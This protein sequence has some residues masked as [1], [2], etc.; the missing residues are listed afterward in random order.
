MKYLETNELIIRL[1]QIL[2]RG[3]RH[4]DYAR[5]VQHADL[6][7]KIMTGENM[8]SLMRR[9][10]RREDE[11]LFNQRVRITQ[12]IT[13][14]VAQNVETVFHKIPR[15][16]SIQKMIAYSN[17][18]AD[19]LRRLNDILSK[20]WGKRS[21]DDY[22]STRW[23][24]LN[25]IDPNSFIVLE[26]KGFDNATEL[27]QPYPYEVYAANAIMF[28]Y[29][30]N[31][32]QY[33][34]EQSTKQVW[35]DDTYGSKQVS[36]QVY[37]IYGANQTVQFEEVIDPKE[38][39]NI[40]RMFA[41]SK[42]YFTDDY[43]YF[44]P[45]IDREDY[46]KIT[47]FTPHNLGFV[48]ADRIGVKHDLAT[49]GR[50]YVSPLDEAIPILMKMVKANSELDLTMA[51]HAFPQKIQYASR[52][53]SRE[54]RDGR[55]TGTNEI[56]PSCQGSGYEV[57]TS[58][59]ETITLAMPKAKDD[60]LDLTNIVNYIYPPVDLIRFQDT[61]IE[62]LTYLVKESVFN[63]ELF[64]KQQVSETATGK[65]ISLQHVYD[66]LYPV[67]V[68]YS[69][70]WEFFV[71]SIAKITDLDSDLIAFYHFSKDFKLKSLSDLYIDLKSV[72]DA[73]ASE[74]IKQNIEDDIAR[75]IYSEE[76]YELLKYNVK[77]SW[78]P[79][80]G[81]TPEQIT[82]VVNSVDL[83]SEFTKVFWANFGYIFD[84]LELE[85]LSSGIDFYNLPRDKQWD[86]IE[87]KVNEMM[88]VIEEEQPK[89]PIIN[90]AA[91]SGEG[92]Q[93]TDTNV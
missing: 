27:A 17:N 6:Y 57:I 16:N 79:F 73:R 92:T 10:D 82:M 33:L 75:V 91:S 90:Y 65:N 8:E 32:L 46:F 42:S 83:V 31:V 7:R 48:P 53:R 61:Y 56:C 81:K 74:F 15:S 11:E 60:M 12:H 66:A 85:S 69:K 30:K 5:T 23:I 3:E 9:F 55:L 39:Q 62:K 34:A 86:L 13:K 40:R 70:S 64:S 76:Q 22:M 20:F 87:K 72:G 54:C 24:E 21:L 44:R 29:E 58:S 37:T 35:I 47:A 67:A 51:L 78:F 68:I 52:C 88:K 18:D 25:F 59:Q 2:V 19:K 63:T 1:G 50:S 49:D 71:H 89:E 38:K 26:W 84:M 28:E 45:N 80:N 14:T 4:P 43:L 77:K 93:D 41:R 36:Y